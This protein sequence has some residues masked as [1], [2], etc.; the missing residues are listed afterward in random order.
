MRLGYVRR[1]AD[2]IGAGGR[3]CYLHKSDPSVILRRMIPDPNATNL[4]Y[5]YLGHNAG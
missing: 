5:S 1:D 2:A 3:D 4:F